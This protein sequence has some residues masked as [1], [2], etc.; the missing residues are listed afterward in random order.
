MN[1]EEVASAIRQAVA[2]EH[3]LQVSAVV[4]LKPGSI[5]K[6]SSGKVQRHACRERFLDGTLEMIGSSQLEAAA[7]CSSSRARSST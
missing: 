3:E 5:P 2:E 1:V 7:R 4:L 6:T